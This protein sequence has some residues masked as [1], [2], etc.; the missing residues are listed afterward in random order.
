MFDANGPIA[1]WP[2][3]A[4]PPTTQPRA[5]AHGGTEVI[6]RRK[7]I[8]VDAGKSGG[9]HDYS[10]LR[11]GT[12]VVRI[13]NL[14]GLWLGLGHGMQFNAGKKFY[15]HM[16][17]MVNDDGVLMGK[18]EPF[19]LAPE[20]IEFASGLAI[21]G[22]RVVISYGIDDMRCRIGETSLAAIVGSGTDRGI[23]KSLEVAA[24]DVASSSPPAPGAYTASSPPAAAPA[25][26]APSIINR[27]V[28]TAH[29]ER[30][31]RTTAQHAAAAAI[32]SGPLSDAELDNIKDVAKL[33]TAYRQLRERLMSKPPIDAIGAMAAATGAGNGTHPK[34]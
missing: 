34:R 20:G 19:K 25:P 7:T 24:P 10:G 5:S 11:G 1:G 2:E 28:G 26:K 18:S 21:D 17:Y 32:P 4:P 16:F 6:M 30:A 33:R 9:R 27:V 14:P 3:P 8:V 23:L 13:P 22:D 29:V 31:E 12:Q 15:W